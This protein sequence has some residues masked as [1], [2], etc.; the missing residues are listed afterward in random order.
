[1][2]LGGSRFFN[3]ITG[4]KKRKR[5]YKRLAYS[6]DELKNIAQNTAK[7]AKITVPSKG[8][9][10]KIASPDKTGFVVWLK[11]SYDWNRISEPTFIQFLELFNEA[12]QQILQSGNKIQ[13]EIFYSKLSTW[14]ALGVEK[15]LSKIKLEF[16]KII[17]TEYNYTVN[18]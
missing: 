1:M 10:S 8:Y 13:L 5:Q 17:S 7:V 4:P 9:E 3:Q 15:A 12:H 2:S 16:I 18:L 14:S 11:Y 6:M